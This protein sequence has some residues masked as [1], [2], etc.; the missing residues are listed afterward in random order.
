[1]FNLKGKRGDKEVLN[2][3]SLMLMRYTENRSVS[4]V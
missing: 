1:M 3:S 2:D 4:H